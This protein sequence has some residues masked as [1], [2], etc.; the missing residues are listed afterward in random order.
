MSKTVLCIECEGG[1]LDCFKH[2]CRIKQNDPVN[3]PNHYT[4]GEIETIDYIEQVAEIYPSKQAVS[5]G[6][7]I[8]YISR[9]P[10]KN[11]LEDLKKAQFYLNRVIELEEQ[12]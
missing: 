1:E 8:K 4:Y 2:G 9:A 6:N 12:K 3:Q 11:G 7:V 5:V 10:L